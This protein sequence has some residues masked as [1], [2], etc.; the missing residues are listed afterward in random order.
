MHTF[1]SI[2]AGACIYFTFCT[3]YYTI[4]PHVVNKRKDKEPEIRK[5]DKKEKKKETPVLTNSLNEALGYDIVRII[6]IE[7]EEPRKKQSKDSGKGIN[8]PGSLPNITTTSMTDKNADVIPEDID[9]EEAG[10]FDDGGGEWNGEP[11]F[12]EIDTDIKKK[13]A[14]MTFER[15][16]EE[17][18]ITE[19]DDSD[20]NQER[21]KSIM[22][23]SAQISQYSN[24]MINDSDL[25]EELT[26]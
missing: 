5:D 26:S 13:I 18:I 15:L 22:E 2:I 10:A 20:E 6:T 4:R 25:T 3:I 17:A 8:S 7:K 14:S 1:L 21:M 16:K 24:D 9:G 11:T 12:S 19:I 23:I